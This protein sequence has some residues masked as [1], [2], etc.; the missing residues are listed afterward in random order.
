MTAMPWEIAD[1]ILKLA[2]LAGVPTWAIKLGVAALIFIALGIAKCSYDQSVVDEYEVE[3]QANVTI[4]T[5]EAQ[6]KADAD[7]NAAVED[8]SEQL[9][10]D[11]KEIEDAKS[12]N[13]SPL[14]ALF[15]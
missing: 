5:D 10:Q 8:F 7:L 2:Q 6:A 4:V 15:D 12:E 1:M 9:E 13:R 3:V 14:D 11:R